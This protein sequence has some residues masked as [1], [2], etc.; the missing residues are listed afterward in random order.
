MTTWLPGGNGM[1]E[2]PANQR[3]GARRV[4][5][6]TGSADN[7]LAQRGNMTAVETG[8]EA[9]GHAHRSWIVGVEQYDGDRACLDVADEIPLAHA[10]FDQC[11]DLRQGLLI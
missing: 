1:R 4:S 7:D 10:L 6:V 5:R 9:I 3:A 11:I 8:D 2:R